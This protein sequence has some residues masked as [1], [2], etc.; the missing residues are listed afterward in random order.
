MQRIV[1][2]SFIALIG[3]A[4]LH[5]VLVNTRMEDFHFIEIDETMEFDLRNHFQVYA[6]PGP[7]ATITFD[8]PVQDRN[9]DTESGLWS[10]EIAPDIFLDLMRYKLTD[11]TTYNSP[12]DATAGDMQ[13]TS[14][15]VDYQLLA[16]QAPVTVGNFITYARDGAYESSVIHRSEI[17]VIQGGAYK[18]HQGEGNYIL[19]LVEI[20]PSIVF[21]ETINNSAGTL[22]MARQTALDTATSQYFIN[23]ADNSQVFGSAYSVFGELVNP[24][25]DLPV[26]KQMGDIPVYDLTQ[27][28]STAPFNTI[29]LIAPFFQD[30]QS[31]LTLSSVS[32]PDGNPDG[33]SYSWE[34]YDTDEE[35]SESEAANRAAFSITLE[36]SVLSISRTG[37]AGEAAV[38]VSGSNA[39]GETVSFTMDLIAYSEA[40]LNKF[41]ASTL[42]T[43]GWLES[44]WYGWLYGEYF[45]EITHA[46][47][48]P[49][50]VYPDDSIALHFIYDYN[51]GSWLYTSTSQYPYLFVY[52]LNTWV[53]YSLG[54]GN[55]FGTSRWFYILEGESPGWVI[56]SDL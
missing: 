23:L 56:E 16:D 52:S 35:V 54:S 43:S 55:G 24:D 34:F 1:L 39:D 47:H 10:T 49:Q 13:Y 36:G 51:L 8:L 18:L 48:G 5:A 7:V 27:Y 50:Y 44:S 15:S 21:E 32:I 20:R 37:S 33:V 17:S 41:P 14:Y 46:N 53:Y 26:L 31:Y 30:Q 40:A 3:A 25:V 12:Y 45:P 9:P 22:S 11:G 29:P 6:D 28:Y 4:P 19:D 42:D 38:T 2:Y